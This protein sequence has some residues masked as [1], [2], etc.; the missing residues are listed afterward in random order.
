MVFVS[1]YTRPMLVP[2][3]LPDQPYIKVLN[4]P[5]DKQNEI[6]CN[7]QQQTSTK[8]SSSSCIDYNMGDYDPSREGRCPPE[9][10]LLI[11]EQL[12]CNAPASCGAVRLASKQ[13][14]VL[15]DPIVYRHL[16]LNSALVKCFD[17]DDEPNVSQDIVDMRRSIASAICT[18]TRQITIDRALNWSLVVSMLLSLDQF[19]H[20][21]WHF[22]ETKGYFYYARPSQTL[23]SIF[24]SMAKRWPSANL[25]VSLS[26]SH[27]AL[28]EFKYLTF[29]TNLVSLKQGTNILSRGSFK[30][31]LLQ[32]DQLNVLH[33][34][35]L[36]SGA[37]FLDEEI[38]R[39]ERLP[40]IEELFLQGYDWRHSPSI[41]SSFWN[42]S[43]LTSLRLEKV[44]IIDFLESVSPENFLQ[45][46]SL[47]TDGHC[48]NPADNTRATNLMI[49]LV[50]AIDS[51]ETLSLVCSVK[52]F[53]IDAIRNHGP[54]LRHLQL[55]D[56]KG[57]VHLPLRRDPVTTLSLLDLLE[58]Q[59]SCPK[60]MELGLDVDQG[61]TVRKSFAARPIWKSF[62]I[63]GG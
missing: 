21:N 9:I 16:K 6:L 8:S 2:M 54:G 17:L 1:D 47:I 40:P 14:K 51:L 52:M 34:F 12:H 33:L 45:L 55:R 42:W 43:R 10:L 30:T 46:R 61:V 44:S 22:W 49:K 53:P 24:C 38:G 26:S 37:R 56:F 3:W 19:H 35:N 41:A 59:S 23:Q 18:F 11:F 13:F 7:L 25:S 32:C 63:S 29:A 48:Q 62:P 60:L 28:D 36:R 15:V 57:M 5:R 58:I 20:L 50:R 27:D 31:F 39:S 4:C